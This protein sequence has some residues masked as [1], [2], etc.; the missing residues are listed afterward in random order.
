MAVAIG[1]CL[2]AS[3]MMPWAELDMSIDKLPHT[4]RLLHLEPVAK[5]LDDVYGH[6]SESHKSHLTEKKA[7]GKKGEYVYSLAIGLAL[8]GGAIAIAAIGSADDEEK[9]ILP[10]KK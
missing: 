10:E 7:E 6:S 9:T 5:M 2:W 3:V 8:L 1:L 4:F